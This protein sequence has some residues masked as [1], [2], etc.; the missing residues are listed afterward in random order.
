MTVSIAVTKSASIWTFAIVPED[1]EEADDHDDIVDERHERGDAELHVPEPDRDPEEDA[2][3]TDEDE[4]ECLCD[5]VR[6]DDRADRRQAALLGDG[7]EFGL[8]GAG[9]LAERPLRRDLRIPGRN[10]G[11]GRRGRIR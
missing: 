4:D 1:R 10:D 6:A 11:G 2:D 8:E 7:T 5:E 3:R 9:D